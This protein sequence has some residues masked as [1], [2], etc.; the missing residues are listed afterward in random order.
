M[1]NEEMTTDVVQFEPTH[2][3]DLGN[4]K[5][6]VERFGKD[7]RWCG[8]MPGSGWMIWAGSHWKTD[9]TRKVVRFAA[10]VADVWRDRAPPEV[11]SKMGMSIEEEERQ[12]LRKLMLKHANKCEA[13]STIK[14]MIDL[15]GAHEKIAIKKEA[16]DSDIW[17]FNTPD[18]TYNLKTQ[19]KYVPKREDHITH[20]ANVSEQQAE[21]PAWLKFLDRIMAGDQDMVNFLQRV[22]GYCLTGS[23]KEQCMFIAYGRGANGKSTFMDTI[24]HIMGDYATTTPVETFVNRR[25][26]SIPNDLAALAGVRLVTCSETSEGGGLDEALVKLATGGDPIPAR[27]LNREFFHFIA[28]F[29]LWMLTNHKPIIKGTDEGIWRRLRMIP[30]TVTIPKDERDGDLPAKLRAEA[31]AILRWALTGLKEWQRIGLAP[32]QA[33]MD[34]T[35]AYKEEM[36]IL[37]DFL[38]DCCK[39]APGATYENKLIY[40]AYSVWAKENGLNVRSHKWL[41]RALM[42][43]G[44]TQ[45]ENRHNGRRWIGIEKA[46]ASVPPVQY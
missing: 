40:N 35:D 36:D 25:E 11:D 16:W 19:R 39:V 7:L 37:S 32:P 23:I 17:L 20:I 44:F 38:T 46:S 15:A 6:M 9:D 27:F 31:G 42:D 26:G 22:V 2:M 8:A 12:A 5:L 3:T 41:S 30:F 34:A 33:V 4:A 18:F 10:D 43:R 21:C 14:A 1:N 24:M 13:A 45:D 29:K 28:S